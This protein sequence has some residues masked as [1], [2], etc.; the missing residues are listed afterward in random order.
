[1]DAAATVR[2]AMLLGAEGVRRLAAA[3]VLVV[4]I[5]GVGSY[6]AEALARG[7]VGALALIDPDRVDKSN[8]NRQLVALVSTLGRLKVEVMRER[9]L[10]INPQAN[11]EALALRYSAKTADAVDLTRFDFVVDAIDSPGAKVELIVRAKAVGTP[12]VSAMGAGDKLDPTCFTLTDLFATDRCPLARVMRKRLRK[13][14]I[15]SLDVV[16]ST[17]EPRAPSPLADASAPGDE[18]LP[19]GSLSFVPGAAGLVIAG[20]V[21]RTLAGV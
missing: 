11:V 18:R 3:R 2:S 17:E 20:H 12:V 14:N 10:D 13:Q 8:L 16:F 4:G 9:I 19:P 6:A 21:I 1:M 5:G 15:T 7:G